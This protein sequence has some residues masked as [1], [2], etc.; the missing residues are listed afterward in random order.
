MLMLSNNYFNCS[1]HVYSHVYY[2]GKSLNRLPR[3]TACKQDL[4]LDTK[5]RY[6]N[7]A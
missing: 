1:L 2:Y 4:G 7:R 5:Y 6:V 3:R